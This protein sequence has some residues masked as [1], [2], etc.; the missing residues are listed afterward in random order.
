M[1]SSRRRRF[2]SG[3]LNRRALL[4]G[5]LVLITTIGCR[6]GTVPSVPIHLE[7][8]TDPQGRKLIGVGDGLMLTVR[9]EGTDPVVVGVAQEPATGGSR[10]IV[11]YGDQGNDTTTTV[12]TS[13]G[14]D[15]LA[16]IRVRGDAARPSAVP[17]DLVLTASVNGTEAARE[18]VT[19]LRIVLDQAAATL[20]NDA[21]VMRT[22]TTTPAM[23][24]LDIALRF[25]RTTFKDKHIRAAAETFHSVHVA[26]VE[27]TVI[28]TNAKGIAPVW[29]QAGFGGQGVV[30]TQAEGVYP[31][32][33]PGATTHGYFSISNERTC[34][35]C[36]PPTELDDQDVGTST[37]GS[38][39]AL[40]AGEMKIHTT[41]LAIPGRGFAW[42]FSRSYRSQA[43]HL[44]PVA[45][46]DFATDWAFNYSDDRLL[47]DGQ[48]IV[49]FSSELRTDVFIA[50]DTPGVFITPMEYYEQLVFNA[51]GDIEIRRQDGMVM[52]YRSFGKDPKQPPPAAGRLMQMEDR[53]GNVM[54]FLYGKPPGLD[55]LVLTTVIDTMGRNI[56]YRYYPAD[57]L[58]PG[59]RGRLQE[60]ED[61][62]RDNYSPT[63]RKVRFD[64]DP[65]GNLLSVTGPKVIKTPTG[66]DFP[67][68]KTY[69]YHY[70]QEAD[71]PTTLKEPDRARLL[72]NL[73]AI[74]YPNEAAV[75]LDPKNPQ[76][77]PT[78]PG[79]KREH[80]TYG[81]DSQDSTSLDRVLG[82]AIG[83][84]NG[85]GVSAGGTITYAYTFVAPYADTTNSPFL[86]TRV[87]DRRGNVTEYVHSPFDTLIERREYTR[88]FRKQEPKDFVTHYRYNHD[89]EQVQM[90]LP[91]GNVADFTFAQDNPDRFQQG[92]QIRTMRTPD[93]KRG[94]DQ[95]AL[96]SETVYEPIY[97]QPA[98]VTDSRG[99]DSAFVS[100]IPDVC[101]RSQRERYTTRHFFD[102]QEGD[103]AAV[104]PLLADEL[105]TSEAEVRVRLQA[106]GIALGLGDL[107]QD[108]DTS[109]RVAGNVVRRVAPSVVLLE[110]SNQAAI[111][112][113]RCQDSVT[114]NRYNRF[115][116]VIS[117][118]DAERNVDLRNYFP[119][120]DPD[121]D[122][123]PSPTSADGR[124][125]ESTT[126]GYLAEE[127]KDTVSDPIRNN[128][129]NP[130]PVN[131]RMA[132]TYDD[133][134]NST[135][136]TD[137]RGIRT[138]FFV[139]ELNQV[140]QT[141]RAA[142]APAKGSGNPPEP[143]DLVAFA[144]KQNVFYDF[145][146]NVTLRQVEDRG[147]TSN[148]GGFGDYTST[149]D[150]LDRPI[151]TTSEVNVAQTLVTRHRYDPNGNRVLTIYPEGNANGSVYDERDLLFQSTRGR[152]TRVS[153][154]LYAV[155]DPTVFNRPGG[156]DTKPSITTNNYDKNRNLIEIVDAEPNGGTGSSIAGVGDAAQ[157][158]FDGFDRGKTVTDP[159]GNKMTRFY[160]P[161]DNAVRGIADGDPIDDVAGMVE[162]KTLVV[163][164]YIHDERNRVV[165]THRVL[166]R[167]PDVM[168]SRT[169]TLTDTPAMDSLAPYLSDASSDAASVPGAAGIMIL[170]RVTTITE[171]DRKGRATFS[172]RDD[173]DTYRTDYDGA[174]RMV[175]TTDSALDNGFTVAGIF[176]PDKIAGNKLELAYD[177]NGNVIERKETDVTTVVNVA[178]EVFRSTSIYDAL[179][180]LQTELDNRGQAI[181][182]RYDSRDNPVTLADA[183]G[184]VNTRSFNRRGLGS[185]DPVIINDFGNVTRNRYDGVNRLLETE[186]VLTSSGKGDGSNIGATLEGVFSTTPTPDANQSADGLISTYY[187]YDDNSQL[188]ALRDDNGNT[189]AYTYDN[190]NRLL[191]KRKGLALVGTS[192]AIAGGD[193]GAFNVALRGGATPVD[194]EPNGTDTT[195][196]YDK[197]SNVISVTDEAGN[198][199][200]FSFDALNRS[201]NLDITRAAGF[202]GTD[203][204]TRDYDGL[205]RL[206]E[207]TDNNEPATTT[208]DLLVR[209]FY[210]SLSRKVEESQKIGPLSAKASSCD[211]DIA[212]GGAVAEA[213]S[214][215]YPDSRT[216][217][218]FY[219]TLDRLVHK[220]D[221]GQ[222]S[223]IGTYEYLG[224]WRVAVLMYQNN[225]RLSHIGQ[226]GGQNANVGFDNL[227]RVVN[228]RWERFSQGT[229][230]GNGTLIVGFGHQGATANPSYDRMNHKLIEEKLH[231]GNSSEVYVYDSTY[232][233]TDPGSS[234]RNITGAFKRGTLN[235]GKTDISALTT[236][237]NQKQQDDWTLDGLDNW[238]SNAITVQGLGPV[239]EN[240]THTDFNE[241]NQRANGVNNTSQ[242]LDKNGNITDTGNNAV[243]RNS[244]PG[245]GL[246]MEWDPLNRLRQVYDNNNTPDNINDDVLLVSLSYDSMNRRMRMVLSNN[247]SQSG[248]TDFYYHGWRVLEEHDG[249]DNI[250]QQ[251]VYG[252]YLDEVWTLDDRRAGIAVAQLNDRSGSQRRF[253]YSNTLYSIYALTG[254]T[255]AMV[256]AYQ[257]N[258]YGLPTVWSSPGNDDMFFTDDDLLSTTMNGV[259]VS[260]VNNSRLYT[261]QYWLPFD[262][263]ESGLYY[264]KNR[265][266]SPDLGRFVSRDPIEEG[267]GL[268]LYS[269]AA[270]DP[271]NRADILGL[272]V[273]NADWTGKRLVY[274]GTACAEAGDTPESLAE[275]ITGYPGD[276][277]LLSVKNVNPGDKVDVSPLLRRLEVR[278]RQNVVNA[279]LYFT[280]GFSNQPT[281]FLD[282]PNEDIDKYFVA[283]ATG[284][285]CE[286]FSAA[287]LVY[288]KGLKD[289]IGADFDK[290]YTMRH[291]ALYD[292]MKFTWQW[293]PLVEFTE[294]SS[295]EEMLNGDWGA[296]KNYANYEG[297]PWRHENIIKTAADTFWGHGG[298]R[299]RYAEWEAKLQENY[300]GPD[301]KGAFGGF[302]P[303]KNKFLNVLRIAMEVWDSRGGK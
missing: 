136:M 235:S 196:N 60:V 146:N 34:C 242:T 65:A 193:S 91:E 93:A 20:L 40:Y 99:L 123:T 251:Y 70:L 8:P 13:G 96:F 173:L 142:A 104:L 268:N 125:L 29:M 212:A 106:A 163:T 181:D 227:R 14:T 129:T 255:G 3:Q 180:R 185:S 256:E 207:S 162:N 117:T 143:M 53:N 140:V 279:A 38:F 139:N 133:V 145:N 214:C 86:Q 46:G 50:S 147:N 274:T 284:P 283:G 237:P 247:G 68:G 271:T 63:G 174:D 244:F 195:N 55:K 69:R 16:R 12:T 48:N 39:V 221:N 122:R 267:D 150:I 241:I 73:V 201:K 280:A 278:M 164:E 137:G 79:T 76:T 19:V 263:P 246:R 42:E 202:I 10:G 134:G 118:V 11:F 298:G 190:Q 61:F 205:S 228:H 24:N 167:T 178:D 290:L 249:N 158:T 296:I 132:Y 186:A 41:D 85:N 269:Y 31:H 188:L 239:T 245:G 171:Y 182:Y 270:S 28:R 107:N 199:F 159:L 90:V 220:R 35:D 114:L 272:W 253:Y 92:N 102:Y 299:L 219:D 56:A 294:V 301:D 302:M 229:A 184:S 233:L 281:E 231:D 87:T 183:V 138:D 262:R 286:C 285:S 161:D 275:L 135:S 175:R 4:L 22:L 156:A 121:G 303:D 30:V 257:Y 21:P 292:P 17:D 94:G 27:G 26:P 36:C 234:Y 113:D 153:A 260:V 238:Q 254:E 276:A 200:A 64:Y 67:A 293:G 74:E 7:I 169:P 109:P 80:L 252:H 222:T 9:A 300:T 77:L 218:S 250:T 37:A 236:R 208:D 179:N 6:T 72:H 45:T 282:F 128:R 152:L 154:G 288:A 191:V 75:E 95:T 57:D 297:G 130:A 98:A 149:Y 84:T 211:Y 216:V 66:N 115:G 120:T 126:G 47:Q 82:Y 232:R 18:S 141:V 194:S 1:F 54:S 155:Q 89:K 287:A 105:R 97:Q 273:R 259:P 5:L 151:Q 59:R 277:N 111:E 166:F 206:T 203:R 62:R 168:P 248:T 198:M 261:G 295:P 124:T 160:D 204:Q 112:G 210:D 44:R 225:T 49:K 197:D 217:D 176:A 110:G 81:T 264:H 189:I 23:P 119:E 266:Y 88:G 157:Y 51:K 103:P 71:V 116:Q 148:T 213:S 2:L 226:S 32:D 215:T 289:T 108:G 15:N 144:Y 258:V 43:S 100:P 58:N 209:Y 230:L 83:R 240:R 52:T 192:F 33:R 187:A 25:F 223:N 78:P 127:I 265:Y 224:K 243:S 172:V 131:I 170:G 101:D 291:I 177:D 165:A